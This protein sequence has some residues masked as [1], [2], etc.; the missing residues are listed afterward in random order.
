MRILGNGAGGGTETGWA[1]TTGAGTIGSFIGAPTG[2]G[3]ASIVSTGTYNDNNWHHLVYVVDQTAKTQKFFVDGRIAP[4]TS[5]FCGTLTANVLDYSACTTVS[6][7]HNGTNTTNIGAHLGTSQFFSGL[8]DEVAIWNR[9]LHANEVAQFY[10][11]GANRIKFQ[12]RTC[13]AADCSDDSV[14]ANWKGP[15]GTVHSYFSELNSNSS[16]LNMTADVLKA[17][18]ALTLS[19]FT[20]PIGTSRYFQYRTIL[21]SDDA[22]TNCNYGAGATWC[23]PELKSVTVDPAH[24]ISGSTTV[25]GKTGVSFVSLT[26]FVQNADNAVAPSCAGGIGYNLGVGADYSSATWYWWDAAANAG[27]GGWVASDGTVAQSNTA[28]DIA[29]QV[30]TFGTE[31][32]TGSVY[33]KAFLQSSGTAACELD[34]IRLDGQQ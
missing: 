6:A 20:S 26:D 14:G 3:I 29:A 31:V 12:V 17:L 30:S 1:I 7:T 19:G 24:Y 10:R 32:G 9:A 2:P 34:Q 27:G 23:S 25:T 16:P 5:A 13:T 33:F 18:P 21:E 11:R 28:S 4:I 22:T 8:I 15:D